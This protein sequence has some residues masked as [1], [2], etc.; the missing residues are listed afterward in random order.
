MPELKERWQPEL[1][2]ET[3]PTT[4]SSYGL[5]LNNNA[6]LYRK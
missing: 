3:I 6:K 5:L 4:R 1:D 2:I